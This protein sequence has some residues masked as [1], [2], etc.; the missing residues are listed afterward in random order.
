MSYLF[1]ASSTNNSGYLTYKQV[2]GRHIQL[3]MSITVSQISGHQ[4]HFLASDGNTPNMQLHTP[5]D[6]TDPDGMFSSRSNPKT[7]SVPVTSKIHTQHKSNS[8]TKF[9]RMTIDATKL[10]RVPRCSALDLTLF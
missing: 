2:G 10:H 8:F 1:L 6:E 3:L 7:S 9:C 4:K 5:E